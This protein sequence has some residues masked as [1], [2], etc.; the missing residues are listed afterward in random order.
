MLRQWVVKGGAVVETCISMLRQ[1][2]G[3]SDDFPCFLPP[4]SLVNASRTGLKTG[5]CDA[6]LL[7]TSNIIDFVIHY[8][9]PENFEPLCCSSIFYE[10]P[11][12]YVAREFF[13]PLCCSINLCH[14]VA[15]ETFMRNNKKTKKIIKK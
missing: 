11:C 15:R 2:K 9:G 1:W 7:W 4:R 5:V 14:Y 13:M 6:M 12:H 8:V 3:K 10:K